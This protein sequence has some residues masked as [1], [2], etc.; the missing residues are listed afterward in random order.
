MP[1]LLG[2]YIAMGLKIT[3]EQHE[4]HT[5]KHLALKFS[6]YTLNKL[7][8]NRKESL[9]T[10]FQITC[11]SAFPIVDWLIDEHASVGIEVV[12]PQTRRKALGLA[13]LS[14]NM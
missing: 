4:A 1:R 13:R 11:E 12:C 3:F 9:P 8:Q 10:L 2:D 7:R 6:G 5:L 14:R